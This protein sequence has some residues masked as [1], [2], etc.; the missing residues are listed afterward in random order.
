MS[1]EQLRRKQEEFDR[2][3]ASATELIA[4]AEMV[5]D[6]RGPQIF[7]SEISRDGLELPR[8]RNACSQHSEAIAASA[9]RHRSCPGRARRRV[10]Y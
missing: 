10:V 6:A 9:A 5:I 4:I 1:L 2:E 3:T 8:A 7:L